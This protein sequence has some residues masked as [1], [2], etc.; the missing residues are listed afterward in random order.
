V[1]SLDFFP[2]IERE[3]SVKRLRKGFTLES[4]RSGAIVVQYGAKLP[5][6]NEERSSDSSQEVLACP[7]SVPQHGDPVLM[8]DRRIRNMTAEAF[9]AAIMAASR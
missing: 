5:D 9:R 1:H 6:T 7:K 4:I 8:L 3:I 2:A